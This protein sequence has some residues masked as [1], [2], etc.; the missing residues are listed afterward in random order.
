MAQTDISLSEQVEILK[1]QIAELEDA[2][3]M[4]AQE[5]AEIRRDLIQMFDAGAE[6]LRLSERRA[7][8]V[9]ELFAIMQST[10]II[11]FR[12]A[13]KRLGCSKT[14]LRK[15]KPLILSDSRFELVKL[16]NKHKQAQYIKLKTYTKRNRETQSLSSIPEKTQDDLLGAE[17]DSILNQLDGAEKGAVPKT[18]GIWSK[19]QTGHMSGSGLFLE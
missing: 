8:V 18:I 4:R 17:A 3:M 9:D 7:N 1:K 6:K 12:E 5:I 13:A 16:P 15:L 11:S 10:P 2:N 19:K 14:Y